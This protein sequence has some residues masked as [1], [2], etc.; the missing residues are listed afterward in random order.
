MSRKSAGRATVNNQVLHQKQHSWSWAGAAVSPCSALARDL[1]GN[2][3]CLLLIYCKA[4]LEMRH[5]H[6]DDRRR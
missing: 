2:D 6:A 1:T 5:L 3:F 4:Q